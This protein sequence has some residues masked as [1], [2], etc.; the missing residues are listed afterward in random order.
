MGPAP[1]AT[2]P[3]SWKAC[4][5]CLTRSPASGRPAVNDA[6]PPPGGRTIFDEVLSLL[7]PDRL[8]RD[9]RATGEGVS[10]C[11]IDSGVER[12]LLEQK[13]R[14]RGHAIHRIE[15]GV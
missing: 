9:P 8:L 5:T 15:G 13:F 11:V 1:F 14:G 6:Q 4:A 10:V 7:T 2:A 3:A 12:E